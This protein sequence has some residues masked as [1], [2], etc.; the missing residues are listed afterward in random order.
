MVSLNG[1]CVM[2]R[3]LT[4]VLVLSIVLASDVAQ[5]YEDTGFDPDDR[6]QTAFDVGSGDPDIRSTT[7]K[8]WR[9]DS[10]RRRLKIRVRTYDLINFGWEVEV[11]LD[12]R[13]GPRRDAVMHIMDDE[14]EDRCWIH[15]R[16]RPG[17]SYEGTERIPE[18][19]TSHR[20]SCVVPLSEVRPTKRIRWRL[21][22]I[23]WWVEDN[24]ERAPNRGF[25][26]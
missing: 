19:I 7:R 14:S 3:A 20:A 11:L 25:Y 18:P 8:V 4:A 21:R 23:S 16:A 26:R 9:A 1:G 15:P 10:G 6:A 24:P 2:R 5:G 12:S 13:A 22:S 17:Q